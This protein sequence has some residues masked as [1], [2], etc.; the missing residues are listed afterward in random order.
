MKPK[1]NQ[2]FNSQA[3]IQFYVLSFVN[4]I[5]LRPSIKLALL[6]RHKIGT[7]YEEHL[8]R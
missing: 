2:S 4:K 5:P 3:E 8:F 6:M 1:L 7:F